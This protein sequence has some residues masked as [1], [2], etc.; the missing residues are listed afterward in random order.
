MRRIYFLIIIL[1]LLQSC[2]NKHLA[3]NKL[4]EN[5]DPLLL[6]VIWF[7]KS[8]EMQALYYQCYNNATKS[9][10]DKLRS[11]KNYKPKAV[12][13]DID[14]TILDNSPLE[15]YQV[16]NNVGYS[17]SLWNCWTDLA[18]AEPLPGSLEFILFAKSQGVEVFYV[19]NRSERMAYKSTISN[20]KNKG[21]PFADSL[22]L[23]LK[24]STTSKE[25]RR[26]KIASRYDIL[27]LIGDNIGD[28]SSVFDARG[29]DLAFG[30]VKQNM[31]NFGDNFI[32]LPNPMYGPWINAAM[33]NSSGTTTKEK[34]QNALISF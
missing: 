22:H 18:K 25:E 8:P 28:F 14:E 17:D 12:V 30:T 23:I 3:N 11:T 27:L 34:L 33:K 20:L 21:F 10:I 13:M 7:Q 5:Q 32:I 24:T 19:T 6:S 15:A 26:I 31:K 9:L 16:I 29:E 4:P 2:G 1:P